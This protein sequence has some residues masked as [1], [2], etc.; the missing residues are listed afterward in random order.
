MHGENGCLVRFL[1]NQEPQWGVW[2]RAGNS[3]RHEF[4]R[5]SLKRP[6]GVPNGSCSGSQTTNGSS[7]A[8]KESHEDGGNPMPHHQSFKESK[9][10]SQ[11]EFISALKPIGGEFNRRDAENHVQTGKAEF[12]Q[13]QFGKEPHASNVE[14]LVRH[15]GHAAGGFPNWAHVG[16]NGPALGADSK[17]ILVHDKQLDTSIGLLRGH[18]E[19]TILVQ[20]SRPGGAGAL[21]R[22]QGNNQTNLKI[23]KR[24]ARSGGEL[25][26]PASTNPVLLGKRKGAAVGEFS[27]AQR[28]KKARKWVGSMEEETGTGNE[29]MVATAQPRQQI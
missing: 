1:P 17:T 3:Q 16:G 18:A 28:N 23:W 26:V 2:M 5:G 22:T 7:Q 24:V 27:E 6:M 21:Q 12:T 19:I 11:S 4:G 13:D 10:F 9:E 14:E 8:E 15:E 20:G 25:A 29:T